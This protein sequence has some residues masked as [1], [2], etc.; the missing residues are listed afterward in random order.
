MDGTPVSSDRNMWKENEPN[1]TGGDEDYGS[2][3]TTLHGLNDIGL[4]NPMTT[5]CSRNW[6]SDIREEAQVDGLAY[7]VVWT[8]YNYN[9]GK[10][11]CAAWGGTYAVI[12]TAAQVGVLPV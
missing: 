12:H 4:T 3:H 5:I 8:P 9:D 1:Q 10:A 11:V 7:A 2:V 6:P